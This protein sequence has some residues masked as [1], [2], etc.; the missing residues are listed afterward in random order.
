MEEIKAATLKTIIESRE[1][2]AQADA[3]LAR[4]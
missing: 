1:L 3:I 4:R 2:M